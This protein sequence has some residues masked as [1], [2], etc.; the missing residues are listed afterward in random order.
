MSNLAS[1]NRFRFSD[2]ITFVTENGHNIII[3][4]TPL[5]REA[6]KARQ[7][8]LEKERQLAYEQGWKEC[9]AKKLQEIKTAQ[10]QIQQER[11]QIPL[12]LNAYL[13]ELE[14]QTRDEIINLSFRIA[15]YLLENEMKNR[16]AYRHVLLNLLEEHNSDATLKIFVNP[17]VAA[18]IAASEFQLRSGVEIAAD[19]ALKIGEVK[20]S[21]GQGLIDGR[22][23]TRLKTLHEEILKKQ[24]QTVSAGSEEEA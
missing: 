11:K 15:E 5:A 10:A 4:D 7:V 3:N 12:M 9:E 24:A 22:F 18:D 8:D 6:E 20:A 16:D 13:E 17:T 21:S 14:T 19:P 2:R 23:T 1:N